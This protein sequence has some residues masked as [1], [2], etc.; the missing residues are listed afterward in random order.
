MTTE[1][2]VAK[3]KHVPQQLLQKWAMVCPEMMAE[4]KAVS[5]HIRNLAVPK[6][7]DS[8]LGAMEAPHNVIGSDGETMET[9]QRKINKTANDKI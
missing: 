4:I 1:G 2:R 3:L 8:E 5:D 7:P 6:S 9:R